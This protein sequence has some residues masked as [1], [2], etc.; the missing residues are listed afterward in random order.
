MVYNLSGIATNS[1]SLIG[2]V[3]GVNDV[4]MFGWL[5]TML[6]IGLFVV[7]FASYNFATNDPL[8]A[9]TVASFV[10]MI[11]GIL[12]RAMGL[13]HDVALIVVFVLTGVSLAI[14]SKSN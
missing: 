5:G 2:M 13:I 4:L 1:T 7:F 6:L 11:L 3:Q 14:S 9:F 8:K 12:L 10:C